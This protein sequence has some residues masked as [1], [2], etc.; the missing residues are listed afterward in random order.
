MGLDEKAMPYR[1]TMSQISQA[2]SQKETPQDL[3]NSRK[4]RK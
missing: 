2:K 3:Y 1:A 4:I